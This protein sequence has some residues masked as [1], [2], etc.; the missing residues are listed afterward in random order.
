MVKGV[1]RL[2]LHAVVNNPMITLTPSNSNLAELGL[3]DNLI[4]R[5]VLQ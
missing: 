2:D 4:D 5:L 3:G 1:T